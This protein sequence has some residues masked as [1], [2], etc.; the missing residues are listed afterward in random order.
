[1]NA[2]PSDFWG[3]PTWL[4]EILCPPGTFDPCPVNPRFDGLQVVWEGNVYCNPP[5][6]QAEQWVG[7]ALAEKRRDPNRRIIM[8]LPNWTDRLWFQKLQAERCLFHF[9]KRLAFVDL[10]GGRNKRAPR[11]GSVIV[12]ITDHFQRVWSL[13]LRGP[14]GARRT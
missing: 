7:K 1:M 10:L 12:E 2:K 9:T 5:Y 4:M 13:D 3:T 11:F 14:V 6:S 8:L